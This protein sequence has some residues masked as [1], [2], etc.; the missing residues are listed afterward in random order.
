MTTH[1]L[2]AIEGVPESALAD[3]DAAGLPA[4]SA[5]APWTTRLQA[6][7]WW[8]R[9]AQEAAAHLPGP[10]RS[11]R[12]LPVTVG[13]LIRYIETPV[14]PYHEVLGAPALLAEWPLPA[15]SVAFI[16]VDSAASVHGGRANWQ[17]PKTL[18]RFE[19]PESTARGFELDAEGPRWSV[20]ATV[21][22]RGRRFPVA[23]PLRNR[24]VAPDG[25]EVTFTSRARG[26]ARAAAVELE[27]R[28]ST[29]PAWLRSGRHAALVIDEARVE[30]AAARSSYRVPR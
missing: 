25:R 29:L 14:G 24:Q 2:Q 18:A 26:Q 17:L 1:P 4:S 19:W 21:R 13:A 8:H 10:L 12:T 30:I 22:P 7:V 23:A 15:A 5:P 20:H 28:G 3:D 9:A 6:V 16:A 27:S 11:R